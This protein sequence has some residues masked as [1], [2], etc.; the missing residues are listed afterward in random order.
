MLHFRSN[1]PISAM[2]VCLSATLGCSS[3]DGVVENGDSGGAGG[4]AGGSGGSSGAGGGTA[5]GMSGSGGSGGGGAGSGGASASGGSSGSGGSGGGGS[6]SGGSSAKGGSTGSGGAATGGAGTGDASAKGGTTGFGG[7]AAGGSGAGGSSAQGGGGGT[8]S[9]GGASATGSTT[10]AGGSSSMGGT[11]GAGGST[12]TGGGTPTGGATSA[13]G[14][15]GGSAVSFKPRVINTTDLKA[16]PDDEQSMVRQLV[17]ADWFD[18]EGLVVTTGCWRKTQ[19]SSGKALLDKIVNAYGQVVSNLKVH[20]PDF[21]SLEY[22]KSVSVMGQTGY[23]MGG[24][25]DGKDSAGSNLIIA[26]VDKP[27]PRPVWVTC[28]GGCNTIAQAIWKVQK[29]RSA[30]ELKEFVKKLR[31]YDVLGQDEAAAWLAHTFPD[32]LLVIRARNLVY[33][34]QPSDAWVKSEVQSH[35]A[36]GGVYPNKAYAYEGDTPA[37]LHLI[38]NGLHDPSVPDQGGWGGRFGPQ[39][40]CG[41][42]AME[43]VTGQ[44]TYNPYCLYTDA[45]E[46][47]NSISRWKAAIENDFAARMDWSITSKYSDANHQPI[48]VVNGD[49]S[50]NVLEVSAAGGSSV[51]L[52]AEGSSDPDGNTLAYAWQFYKEPSSYTG[53]VTIDGASSASANVAVPTGASGKTIHVIFELKD[54]GKPALVAYRRVVIKIQ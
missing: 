4:S 11:T 54:N 36:L 53:S 35:G 44:G 49:K 19:D 21:P 51:T 37:F 22:M 7:S 13:G 1:F 3:S 6:G 25:G 14:S 24:V 42:G 43:P 45:A 29:T 16:D 33:A 46:G 20:S 9:S 50:R 27:D 23:S 40:S 10:A 26:S 41:V 12:A 47:G 30:T 5:G 38:P 34:W 31:V 17:Y 15:G 2:A 28:W 48:A 8:A 39:K 18:L 52:S 32:D